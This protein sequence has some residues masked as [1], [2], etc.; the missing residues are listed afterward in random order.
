MVLIA[1]P[2]G[3][4]LSFFSLSPAYESENVYEVSSVR[5]KE[6]IEPLLFR[7]FVYMVTKIFR[8]HMSLSHS[9]ARLS[10]T[11]G[12][13]LSGFLERS[14]WCSS[15]CRK[16]ESSRNIFRTLVFLILF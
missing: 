5:L 2:L 1:D 13:V 12:S 15:V 11:N 10:V 14:V 6:A 4:E 8:R 7:A 16:R 3:A 9:S